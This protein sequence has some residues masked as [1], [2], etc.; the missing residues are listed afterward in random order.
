MAP[1]PAASPR[2]TTTPSAPR[3][4]GRRRRSCRRGASARSDVSRRH[5]TSWTRTSAA[6]WP[7]PRC[8]RRRSLTPSARPPPRWRAAPLPWPTPL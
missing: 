3:R 6:C 7:K 4:D 8:K 2:A 5:S 1:S